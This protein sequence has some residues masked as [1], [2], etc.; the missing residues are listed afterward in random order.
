MLTRV[1]DASAMVSQSLEATVKALPDLAHFLFAHNQGKQASTQPLRRPKT[2]HLKRVV[3]N[4][5]NT[6]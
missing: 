4:L 3:L 2:L 1:G 5:Q 6:P